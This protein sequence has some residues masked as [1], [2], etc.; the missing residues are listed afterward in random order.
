MFWVACDG[1]EQSWEAN[2][3]KSPAVEEVFNNYSVVVPNAF[4]PNGDGLNDLFE[5]YYNCLD[6]S[7]CNG[8]TVTGVSMTV[9]CGSTIV[10]SDPDNSMTYDSWDGTGASYGIYD[11]EVEVF[12][13]DGTSFSAT[14][15]VCSK[16]PAVTPCSASHFCQYAS[17]YDGEGFNISINPGEACP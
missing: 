5:V 14:G 16:D 4:T 7:Q 13:S 17:V 8:I 11:Y 6:T 9:S 2:C 15:R 10:F 3:C 12:F 1:G